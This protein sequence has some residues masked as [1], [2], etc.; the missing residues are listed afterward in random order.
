MLSCLT[1]LAHVHAKDAKPAVTAPRLSYLDTNNGLNQD[2]IND[3]IV[4]K[5]GF[6]WI[7]TDEGLN[8]FDGVK[9]LP[10][11]GKNSAL[12]A[13][14]IFHILEH[15]SGLL[16]LST[17]NLGIV[18]LDKNTQTVTTVLAKSY[19]DNEQW[20]QYA[21]DMI[22]LPNGNLLVPLSEGV[23]EHNVKTKEN[24]LVYELP[25]DD[26]AMGS[27]IR[28]IYLFKD[29]LYVG[30]VNGLVA[31]QLSTNIKI[32]L[33][34]SLNVDSDKKNVKY[35]HSFD[36]KTLLVGT[37]EGLYYYALGEIDKVFNDAWPIPQLQTINEN[38]NIWDIVDTTEDKAYVATDIGVFTLDLS[39]FEFD[40]LFQPRKNLEVLSSLDVKNIATDRH[41]NLWMGTNSRG[42]MYWSPSSLLFTNVYNS[43]FTQAEHSLSHNKVYATYQYDANTV[44][45]ATANG[46]NKYLLD[47]GEIT[48]YLRQDFGFAQYTESDIYS[49]AAV[50]RDFLWLRTGA[51]IRKFDVTANKYADLAYLSDEILRLFDQFSYGIQFINKSELMLI[52]SDGL[53]VIDLSTQAIRTIDLAP[54]DVSFLTANTF[55]G[56]DK[57]TNS[58]ILSVAKS[59]WAIDI[60]TLAL[61]KIHGIDSVNSHFI[62]PGNWLRAKNGEVWVSYPGHG[63]Y[64]LDGDSFKVIESFSLNRFLPTNLIYGI[65]FDEQEDLWFS[66]NSGIHVLDTK[67]MKTQ[68]LGFINGLA[69]SEFN[70]GANLLLSDGRMLYGGNLGFTIFNPQDIKRAN[71]LTQAATTITEVTLSTRN[72][73]LPLTSL[74]GRTINLEAEDVGITLYFS[75]LN[76]D[77]FAR[78]RYQYRI[79]SG[80]EII[81]YPSTESNKISLPLLS[82]GEHQI[83]IFRSNTT[84][85]LA[86]ASLNIN[87]AYPLFA[88]PFA[89]FCYAIILCL[90][91]SY[92]YYRQRRT[93]KIINTANKQ[94]S[95]YNKRLKAA[96]VA[97]NAN[98]WEWDASSNLVRGERI[99]E[100]LDENAQT[101]N[102]RDTMQ[103]DD[104]VALIHKS[105]RG[106]FESQWS[107]FMQAKTEAL[108][109]SYRMQAS[110]GK[111]FFY[112]DVGSIVKSESGDLNVKGTYTNLTSSLASQE[113]LKLFGNA[114]KHTR[115]WVL[116][117][118]ENIELI[119]TNPALQKAFGFEKDQNPNSFDYQEA[120]HRILKQLAKMQAGEH[121][122]TEFSIDLQGK[123]L[124]LLSDFNAIAMKDDPSVIDYYLIIATDITEQISAQ[125][126][127]QKL[128]NYDVLTG[129][130][131]RTLLL[132]RLKQSIHFARRHKTQL[133]TLF[134]DLDGFKPINDSF[135]H[136]AGDAVLSEIANR[137]REKFREQDSVARLGGDEFVVVLEEIS[138]V[139][140]V[141][142]IVSDLLQIIE[143]PITISKQAISISASIG[144]AMY[145]NDATDAQ[146]LLRNADIAMYSAKQEGKNKYIYF[147]ESMNTELQSNTIL[148][149]RLKAAVSQK[150]FENYYQAIVDIETG[151]TAGFEMLMRWCDNGRYVSPEQFIPIAEQVGCIVDMTMHAINTTIIDLATWYKDGFTGYVA[152]NLSA[153]QFANRPDFETILGWLQK[154]QLPSSCLRFEITEGLLVSNDKATIDYMHEMRSL[155]FKIS[156]D[157]FGTGYS[158]LKYIKDF[159]LDV[160][161]IDRSFVQ[162]VVNNKGTESIV[163]S[164]LMMTN[165]LQLDTVAEG[166]ETTEQLRYF[167]KQKCQYVQGYYFT[168]PLPYE[169]IAEQIHKNWY[170][171]LPESRADNVRYLDNIKD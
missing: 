109:I 132:E 61:T 41:H 3:I 163:E 88:S 161:K 145:P 68:S 170:E 134:I 45:V 128:A 160:L 11:L 19:A 116:I 13:N 130:I 6:V 38:R 79:I 110:H 111:T 84:S 143:L 62:F 96:L 83:E 124:T 106:Q 75:S 78:T 28:S 12:N 64:K 25:D 36:A 34:E 138:D 43:V 15:S 70:E 65:M 113:K 159:P 166:I 154:Y 52:S 119:A 24:T 74:N 139:Q 50:D 42:A 7:G 44:Y 101:R 152:I 22:E 125:K 102:I 9:V 73:A 5:Q 133:A 115:D 117:F 157:D 8:R 108:D 147:T 135:G 56:M 93:Q 150:E 94:V 82:P 85:P 105:D 120:Y 95:V 97:S 104:Y 169:H 40:Y 80:G 156:L 35:L 168:K 171:N 58:V 4:D 87:V 18:S 167:Q 146:H 2:T 57:K 20:F 153:K 155:G 164:T 53:Y 123:K 121:W 26:K 27:G 17:I 89:Y 49:I 129:L 99:K 76:F 140:D 55:L 66:S 126:E 127:L 92:L 100:L 47:S 29:I 69:S 33:F 137:L 21:E 162:D 107:A 149:N 71:R 118:N 151:D 112:R 91:L 1:F 23:Y 103:L 16:Y 77:I 37:V 81:N 148:Q 122:K 59:V 10:V 46:L 136:L 144:I 32:D 31:H 30:S 48:Q 131:N 142:V 14:S 165:L 67:T 90:L 86:I 51:G 141:N 72:L 114:F 39:S 60:E 54:F 158:S 63:I 98:I